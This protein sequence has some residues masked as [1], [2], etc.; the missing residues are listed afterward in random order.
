MESY[1][2]LRKLYTEA[3]KPDESWCMCQALTTLKNAEPDE[4]SFFKKHKSSGS[5]RPS[6]SSSPRTCG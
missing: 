2:A 1:Q 4:E 3:K 6:R 5:P